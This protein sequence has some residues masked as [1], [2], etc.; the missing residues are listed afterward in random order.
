MQATYYF[1][2]ELAVSGLLVEAMPRGS[3]ELTARAN[4]QGTM[5]CSTVPSLYKR[6]YNPRMGAEPCPQ[7][8]SQCVRWNGA[9]V[10]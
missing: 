9:M 1:G 6:P 4:Y 10:W 7:E 2:W 8:D 3:K 5:L